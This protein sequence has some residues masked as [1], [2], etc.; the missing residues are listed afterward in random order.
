MGL[1]SDLG[2]DEVNRILAR[3]LKK[4]HGMGIPSGFDP[5]ITLSFMAL[6]VIPEIRITPRGLYI[7]K[8][9]RMQRSPFSGPLTE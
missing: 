4:A 5:F 7:V 3:M 2:F 8:E 1:M 6:P 9:D